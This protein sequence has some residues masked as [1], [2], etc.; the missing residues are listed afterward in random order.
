MPKAP[1]YLVPADFRLRDYL[2]REAWRLGE[3]DA[4]ADEITAEVLFLYPTSPWADRQGLG[5]LRREDEATGGQVRAFRARQLD[6]FLRWCLSFPGQI[7]P[8]A[9]EQPADRTV[10]H[11]T[12]R[13]HSNR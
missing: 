5:E 13:R 6:P 11:R 4:D 8:V 3:D 12:V 2:G 1:D 7:R 9:P 10:D